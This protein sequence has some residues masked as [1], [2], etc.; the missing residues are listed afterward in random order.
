[1]A[2]CKWH[3]HLK[4][5]GSE[6]GF[7]DYA[8]MSAAHVLHADSLRV[9]TE[10]RKI[11]MQSCTIYLLVGFFYLVLFFLGKKNQNLFCV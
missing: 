6:R 10:S 5:Y 3:S 9:Q 7:K 8:I 1:M 2:L 11:P 4:F